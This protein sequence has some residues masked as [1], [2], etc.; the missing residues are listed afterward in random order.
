MIVYSATNLISKSIYY[1]I[2]SDLK[3]RKYCHKYKSKL[4][5]R[6]LKG[7][8]TPFYDAIRKYGWDNFEWKILFEGSEEQCSALEIE[9]IQNTT[10]KCYNLHKGGKIGF[11]MKTKSI[12]EYLIWK[13][14]LCNARINKKP[15]LGMKH[16][17]ENKKLFAKVSN[18]YWE[19]QFTYPLEVVNYKFKEANIKFGISKTHYYRLRK[20]V[21]FNE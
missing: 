16:S 11:S 18:D 8:K 10:G 20:R 19:T 9:L 5:N 15:A 13:Q 7:G 3:N 4:N 6:N 21:L 14:K 1:G 17:E 12:E 2:T